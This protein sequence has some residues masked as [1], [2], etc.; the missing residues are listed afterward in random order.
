MLPGNHHLLTARRSTATKYAT[1]INLTEVVVHVSYIP[2]HNIQHSHINQKNTNTDHPT[3][4]IS[5][6]TYASR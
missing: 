4:T 2:Q 3:D 5:A 1:S 6:C